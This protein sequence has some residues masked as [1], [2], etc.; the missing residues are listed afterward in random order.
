MK[1]SLSNKPMEM[2]RLVHST[3]VAVSLHKMHQKKKVWELVNSTH[4][5]PEEKEQVKADAQKERISVRSLVR[6]RLRGKETP[7]DS[8]VKAIEQELTEPQS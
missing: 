1:T 5:T 3:V 6:D 4:L 8:I 7:I 2:H